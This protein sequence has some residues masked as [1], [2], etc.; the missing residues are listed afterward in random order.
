MILHITT[1]E[2]FISCYLPSAF[3]TEDECVEEYEILSTYGPY[4]LYS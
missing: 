1:G 4:E 3:V 2:I